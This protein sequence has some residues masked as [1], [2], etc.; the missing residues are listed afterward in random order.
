MTPTDTPLLLTLGYGKRSIGDTIALLERHWVQ[1]LADVRSVPYSRHHPDFSYDALKAHLEAHNITYLY[2]G[3]ELGGRPKDPDCYDENGRVDYD[4]CRQRTE[5]REGIERLRAAWDQGQRTAL[6]CSE[7]RPENCHRSKLIGVALAEVGIEVTHLDE[8]GAPV[9]Q[10][11]VMNRLL[12]G[13]L[14]LFDDLPAGKAVK[15]RGQYR[16][17]G[18]EW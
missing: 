13:Q 11:E 6:L 1:C 15:S 4:A 14:S 7:S 9:N 10:Q 8:D 3:A 18:S 12:E 16:V 5:F 17:G 2:M